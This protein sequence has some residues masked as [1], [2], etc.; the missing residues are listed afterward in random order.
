MGF[1]HAKITIAHEQPWLIIDPCKKI[2][3]TKR[4][5]IQWILQLEGHF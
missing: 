1:R 4:A 5:I 2:M 3:K